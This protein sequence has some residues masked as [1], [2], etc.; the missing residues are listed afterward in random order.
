[1]RKTAS[2]SQLLA[3][4]QWLCSEGSPC[5]ETTCYG[6]A[7]GDHMAMLQWLHS[8]GCPWDERA[9]LS[10]IK[11]GDVVT[12]Q[13]LRSQGCPWNEKVCLHAIK[14]GRLSIL[15]WLRSQG[16]PWNEEDC[17]KA[18]VRG[19]EYFKHDFPSHVATLVWVCA[20]KKAHRVRDAR[21]NFPQYA[22]IFLLI[23]LC[24]SRTP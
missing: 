3:T 19:V 6:A 14:T 17:V 23:Q 4:L 9:Y 16:C 2:G 20:Q 12:L 24:Y 8:Q 22:K 21:R 1:M 15:Q 7:Q 5:D 13:W 10:A 18:A 11:T